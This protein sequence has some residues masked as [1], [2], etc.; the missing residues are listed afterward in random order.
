MI[1]YKTSKFD[2]QK[3]LFNVLWIRNIGEKGS[4]VV[5]EN[6]YN[7]STEKTRK[8]TNQA[9]CSTISPQLGNRLLL[10]MIRW[11]YYVYYWLSEHTYNLTIHSPSSIRCQLSYV[12][13]WF[14]PS[15]HPKE[16]NVS[17][18]TTPKETPAILDAI[19]M[20]PPKK[21]SVLFL[22]WSCVRGF[23]MASLS[24]CSLS[25]LSFA[26]SSSFL[27]VNIPIFPLW[28]ICSFS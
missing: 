21:K 26:K 7:S 19:L 8:S 4:S 6:V 25:R 18:T 23:K 17:K 9:G 15:E 3:K 24:R 16:N 5:H 2:Y 12:S 20:S 14:L 28:I 11:R 13:C 1:E 10:T 27:T 22:H